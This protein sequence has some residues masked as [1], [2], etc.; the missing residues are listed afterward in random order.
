MPETTKP[1]SDEVTRD[2]SLVE[3]I[4]HIINALPTFQKRGWNAGQKFN[5]VSIEQMKREILPRCA[6]L[7]IIMF[8][9][10]IDRHLNYRDRVND[11]GNVFGLTTE[12]HLIVTWVITD[13][14]STIEIP[15]VGEALDVQDKAANKASTGAQ[16]NLFKTVFGVTEA[17]EDNDANMP[18]ASGETTRRAPPRQ[19]KQRP[20]LTDAQ[21]EML[22]LK[23]E[24]RDT[25]KAV[26]D[27][28]N[29]DS[30][31]VVQ[32]MIQDKL[33]P[34]EWQ[35]PKNLKH[36]EDYRKLIEVAKGYLDTTMD[37]ERIPEV[38]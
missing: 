20:P 26:A 13:G 8:P 4:A 31:E 5:F 29:V 1:N 23:D 33:I 11:S 19:A 16:K 14:E 12:V 2:S 17:D 27:E 37:E 22:Q 3:K 9:K 36:R 34:E 7:G 24:A 25:I 28:K 18:V 30:H 38:E 15:S 6:A 35:D 21:K 10:Q 32:Q